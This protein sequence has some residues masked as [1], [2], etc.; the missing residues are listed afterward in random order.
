M[1]LPKKAQRLLHFKH[2]NT[3]YQIT[4]DGEKYFLYRCESPDTEQ[5]WVKNDFTLLA[6]GNSQ[7][8]LEQKVYDGKVK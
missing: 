7:S 5:W 1:K 6:S 4:K 8:K 3:W 2:K